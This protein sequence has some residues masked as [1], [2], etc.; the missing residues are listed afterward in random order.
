METRRNK[1]IK[2]DEAAMF[3]YLVKH[4]TPR[5]FTLGK[6]R[7]HDRRTVQ[8]LI[9]HRSIKPIF[10]KT[11]ELQNEYATIGQE[12]ENGL[13]LFNFHGSVT[14]ALHYGVPVRQFGPDDYEKDSLGSAMQNGIDTAWE[15]Y[16]NDETRREWM[17]W[18]IAVDTLLMNE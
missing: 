6:G 16:P 10:I 5:G 1:R 7:P 15:L 12:D 3:D 8:S 14:G 18:A 13:A 9:D 11:D 2:K 17:Q 4:A